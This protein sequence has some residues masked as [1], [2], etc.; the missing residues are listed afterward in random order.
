MICAEEDFLQL[1]GLQHFA[2]CRR[3]WALIHIEQQWK[4]NLRTVE[5]DLF[6]RRAHDEQARERRGDVLI[7]RGL[8]V[9]SPTLGISGK[10]DVVE[11]HLSEDGIQLHG[12][13]GLYSIYPIEYKKGK[14]KL[15][16]EDR[17]QLAAQAMCLEEMFSV[18]VPAGAVFYGETRRREQVEITEELR[19]KFSFMPYADI[20][21]ISAV[22]G[23][24]LQNLFTEIDKVRQSQT[25][26]V[27]TGVLNEIMAE[28]CALKQPPSDKGKRLRLYY[29]TQVSIEPPT[30]VIFVNDRELFHFS[31]QRYI[32]N[33]IRDAFS[34]TGT[35]I[36]L[37]I[38]ERKDKDA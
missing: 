9:A 12:H 23:Q 13:R 1:S 30:F 38:R 29:I 36:K 11:F 14:P 3:Q 26:R 10:C 17:L 19:Q 4:E 8:S 20:L 27:Q 18:R 6:H 28:A 5:G 33:R 35:P 24:R 31:Y 34:F 2:F 21:F 7:L 32:E 15:T 25:L 16:E 22:T 37:I